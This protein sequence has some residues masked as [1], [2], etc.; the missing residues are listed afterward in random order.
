[1]LPEHKL[2][3]LYCFCLSKALLLQRNITLQYYREIL[4]LDWFQTKIM[5]LDCL[6][7]NRLI[8]STIMT[9]SG[10]TSNRKLLNAQIWKLF[11]IKAITQ[12]NTYLV[13]NCQ[14]SQAE[15]EL[16]FLSIGDFCFLQHSSLPHRDTAHMLGIVWLFSW[17]ILFSI[18]K[19]KKKTK[20]LFTELQTGK[21]SGCPAI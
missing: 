19:V 2:H 14:H 6:E 3:K 7:L 8:W 12:L 13:C 11:Y 21:Y 4:P 5:Y 9:L 18:A 10:I 16:E 15:R 20:T 1:M 17:V